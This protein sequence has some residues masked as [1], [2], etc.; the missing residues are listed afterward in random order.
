MITTFGYF[1]IG[2]LLFAVFLTLRTL[3]RLKDKGCFAFGYVFLL[4][5]SVIS[6]F[7]S[8]SSMPLQSLNRYII[9]KTYEGKII[10]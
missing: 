7:L 8:T 6:I 9:G 3:K 2:V 4:V 5:F 1:A 10:D